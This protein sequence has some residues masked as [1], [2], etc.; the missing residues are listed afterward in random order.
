MENKMELLIEREELE[1][2]LRTNIMEVSFNKISGD[3]RVMN[4][5]LSASHLPPPKKDDPLTQKKIRAI[6]EELLVV[7][8]TKAKGFRTFR[9]ANIT[10]VKRLGSACWCGQSKDH[11]ICDDTHKSL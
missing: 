2:K 4:C 1:R 5:T 9:M 10:E 7:W 11:P 8:D 6:N 3:K